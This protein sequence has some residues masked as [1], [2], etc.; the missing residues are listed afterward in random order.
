[1]SA[2][3]LISMN[4]FIQL[5]GCKSKGISIS[6][7]QAYAHVTSSEKIKESMTLGIL[8]NGEIP[9][10]RWKM[11]R[12]V[13]FDAEGY[14]CG[15]DLNRGVMGWFFLSG[16]GMSFSVNVMPREYMMMKM[17]RKESSETQNV[18]RDLS[19][20]AGFQPE[21]RPRGRAAAGNVIAVISLW[22]RTR[23]PRSTSSG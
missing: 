20:R 23:T 5:L 11:E 3:L 12:T 6:L 15:T 8:Y 21:N 13:R 1:M 9:S 18:H 14:G 2:D 22:T 7:L 17:R 4:L 19:K 10:D 16:G